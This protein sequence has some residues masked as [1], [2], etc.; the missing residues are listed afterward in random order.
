MFLVAV[1]LSHDPSAKQIK[2]DIAA[3]QDDADLATS[4]SLSLLH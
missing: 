3:T 2:I 1:S 4:L